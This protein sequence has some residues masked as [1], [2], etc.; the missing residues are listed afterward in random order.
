[1]GIG[2]CMHAK[3]SQKAIC[4]IFELQMDRIMSIPSLIEVWPDIQCGHSEL[5]GTAIHEDWNLAC[6]LLKGQISNNT[7]KKN[8]TVDKNQETNRIFASYAAIT[9]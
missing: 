9:I 5:E 4:N 2:T 1:M 6:G 7:Y 3:G 8:I